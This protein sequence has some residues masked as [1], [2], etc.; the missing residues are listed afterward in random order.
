M[1]VRA[2]VSVSPFQGRGPGLGVRME[3]S[4]LGDTIR[5]LRWGGRRGSAA[6]PA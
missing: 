2:G 3:R 6:A 5:F 4:A 1:V